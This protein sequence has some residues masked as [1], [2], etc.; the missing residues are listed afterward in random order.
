M[1]DSS[2]AFSS[3]ANSSSAASSSASSAANSPLTSPA[4]GGN[5]SVTNLQQ[6]LQPAHQDPVNHPAF[7]APPEQEMQSLIAQI[8]DIERPAEIGIWP[9]APGWWVLFALLAVGLILGAIAL[10]KT[11]KRRAYRRSALRMLKRLGD[12]SNLSRSGLARQLNE[13]LKRTALASPYYRHLYIG[14]AHGEAWREFLCAS[15]PEFPDKAKTVDNLLQS[16]YRPKAQLDAG[17]SIAFCEFWIRQH[18]HM[19]EPEQT[20]GASRVINI[21]KTGEPRHV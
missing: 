7:G 1:A 13:I 12:G 18:H 4:P 19:V 15:S 14:S 2:N 16:V 9:L 10:Y 6:Q 8:S 20:S 11:I 17:V 5:Q 3:A 21:E